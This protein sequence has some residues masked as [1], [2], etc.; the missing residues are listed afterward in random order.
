MA[1]TARKTVSEFDYD[2][3]GFPATLLNVP[4]IRVR[5][6]WTPDL[7]YN[8]LLETMATALAAKPVRLTGN[9]IRF[10]RHSLNMNL[11]EFAKRVGVSHP[12]VLKWEEAGNQPTG[13][14]WGTEKDIRLEMLRSGSHANAR[15]FLKAYEAMGERPA[16][17][18]M[19]LRVAVPA[20]A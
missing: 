7:D 19:P 13:M 10:I 1:K 2:G 3:F 20:G 9:E 15:E 11:V 16:E 8:D 17:R 5:G 14:A 6:V 18:D 12:A 4:M